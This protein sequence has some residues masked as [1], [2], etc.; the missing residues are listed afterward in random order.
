[1][2]FAAFVHHDVANVL[3]KDGELLPEPVLLLH[4]NKKARNTIQATFSPKDH[5]INVAGSECRYQNLDRIQ[6]KKVEFTKRY[7]YHL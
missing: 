3:A 4:L 7:W 1:M 5:S 2:W 6:Q